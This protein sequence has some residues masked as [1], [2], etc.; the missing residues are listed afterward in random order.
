MPA[1]S[2]PDTRARFAAQALRTFTAGVFERLGLP[3]ADAA[4][5]AEV[6]IDA[7]LA[8]IESHGIA[9]LPWHPG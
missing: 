2:E 7:D 4:E 8:G 5:G 1:P 3:P 6:L 9:H